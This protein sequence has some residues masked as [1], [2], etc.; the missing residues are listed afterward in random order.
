MSLDL[1]KHL[2]F[3]GSYHSN[4]VNV[5]I[6]MVC[7]PIILMTSFLLVRLP[8]PLSLILC[9]DLLILMSYSRLRIPAS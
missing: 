7:V 5:G 4:T 2:V 1:E 6:H 9:Y 8:V 3:Y